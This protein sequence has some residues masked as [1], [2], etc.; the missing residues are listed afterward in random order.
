MNSKT[1][2][3]LSIISNKNNNNKYN[4]FNNYSLTTNKKINIKIISNNKSDINN[5]NKNDFKT[6]EYIIEKKEDIL[7]VAKNKNRKYDEKLMIDNNN[8][9]YI[10]R[11]KKKKYDKITE[12]TR[13]LNQI[14]P[15]NHYELIFKGITNLNDNS[16][17]MKN[18]KKPEN[19]KN[20][21]T[22][23]ITKEKRE[24]SINNVEDIIKKYSFNEENKIERRDYINIKPKELQQ[25]NN[26]IISYENK[27]EVLYNKSTFTEKA[28]R[29][30]M[31]I[32]LPIRLK[33]VLRE[34]IRGTICH[35][36]IKRM[37]MKK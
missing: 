10:K 31:K 27:I 3:I 11:I 8:I 12:I 2:I 20:N 34:Y 19:N 21:D 30:M 13:E 15:N 22:E 17:R 5:E 33:T 9:L 25:V 24:L 29:N 6:N 16:D 36:L 1:D 37:K 18:E 23:E 26:I 28:K 32:I 4:F 7:L 35:L 14:E